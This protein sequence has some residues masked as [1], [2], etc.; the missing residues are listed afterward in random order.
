VLGDLTAELVPE[1]DLLLGTSE[2]VIS[3]LRRE[4]RPF[5]AAVASVEVGAADA[6]AQDLDT[7]LTASGNRL[8][9]LDDVELRFLT[10]DRPHAARNLVTAA[11]PRAARRAGAVFAFLKRQPCARGVIVAAMK[12]TIRAMIAMI[13]KA[14][15]RRRIWPSIRCAPEGDCVARGAAARSTG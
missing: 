6:T 4:S 14:V 11:V 8:G 13:A 1:D 5:V 15:S 9:T 7:N 12:T 3:E 2:A 10:N